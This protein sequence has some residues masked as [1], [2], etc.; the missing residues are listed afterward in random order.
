VNSRSTITSIALTT[1]VVT[2]LTLSSCASTTA[3]GDDSGDDSGDALRVV[4]TT[5]QLG[6]FAAEI[7]GDH[8]ALTTLLAPGSSAHHFD[9]SP[10]QLLALSQADVLLENGAGLE[11]F[12]DDAVEVSGF[13]GTTVVAAD[14]VDLDEAKAITLEAGGYIDEH[15]H[16]DEHDHDGHEH[17]DAHED[18]DHDPGDV[19]PHLWTSLRF[20]EGM[21]REITDG[22]AKAD[23]AHASA[24]EQN[25]DAYLSELEHLDEWIAAQ[26]DKVP[27][28]E[29]QFVS[30]HDAMRYYLHDYDISFI[31]SLLPSFED[32]AE[33]SA[34]QIDAL[35]DEITTH[36]VTAIF[37]ESSINPKLAKTIA[38]ETGATWVSGEDVLYVDSLGPAE[39]E[40]A[41]YVAATLHNTRTI[42]EAWGV[43]VDPAPEALSE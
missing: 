12:V 24:Y 36:H 4:A 18:H 8:I 7:G 25:A 16:G 17:A 6:D 22:F 39:S 23:P 1:A 33:P 19:N 3:A 14:G 2:A 35:I 30:G 38:D 34:A 9:P 31:G 32:N 5:T 20:A 29:R 27:A 41:T 21:V 43:S 10:E 26:F 28:A 37:T 40:G 11:G 42:L 15:D 13:D